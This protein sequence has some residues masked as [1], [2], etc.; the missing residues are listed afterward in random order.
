MNQLRR[1]EGVALA[2]LV[3]GLAAGS[4]GAVAQPRP[5]LEQLDQACQSLLKRGELKQLRLLQRQLLLVKPAPQPLAV[6][7]A[8]ADA[9]VRCG[10][11]DSALV[12]LNRY[13][14]AAGAEQVQW[15][16]LQWRAANAALDHPLAASALRRLAAASGRSL[17]QL[18]IPIGGEGA[19]GGPSPLAI[20]VLAGHLDAMGQREQAA[21]L[22]FS[23]AG[24]GV[25]QAQRL[26]QA[27]AWSPELP[28]EQRQRWLELA[29]EQ[30]AAAGAWGLAASLLDQQLALLDNQ[31]SAQRQQIEARRRRLSRRI[32]DGQFLSPGAVRSPRDPGGHAASGQP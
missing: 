8:N 9:L 4:G 20:D 10:A 22:L 27:V 6:V 31:A 19:G 2:A 16:L 7:L 24:S 17:E 5:T 21:Q 1:T 18:Q 25:L 30:A 3:M 26:A 14:P 28:V 32:D 11:P 12:V 15:L 13:S 29:L 23:S